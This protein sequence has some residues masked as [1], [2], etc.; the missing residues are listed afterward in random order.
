MVKHNE[1]KDNPYG[2]SREFVLDYPNIRDLPR[3]Y[4]F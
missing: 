2:L 1:M 3:V 4:R